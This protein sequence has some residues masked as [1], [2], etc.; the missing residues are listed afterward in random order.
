[1]NNTHE[2][3]P[4]LG[5]LNESAINEWLRYQ[6]ACLDTSGIS[7]PCISIHSDAD[8]TFVGA[9][10]YANG[11]LG[12]F[13]CN[14]GATV[15]EAFAKLRAKIPTGAARIAKLRADAQALAD[16]ADKLAAAEA[17]KEVAA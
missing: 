15:A 16:E 2:T 14:R 12:D 4:A 13:H 8:D 5:Q 7:S 17:A 1:M 10:G 6:L 11:R 3:P 9:S